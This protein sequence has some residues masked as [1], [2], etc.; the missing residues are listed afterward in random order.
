MYFD[1]WI[2]G[3]GEVAFMHFI[4]Y[5]IWHFYLLLDIRHVETLSNRHFDPEPEAYSAILQS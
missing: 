2:V 3:V 4:N 1:V 5:G